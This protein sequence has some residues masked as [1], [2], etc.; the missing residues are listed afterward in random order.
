MACVR[1]PNVTY[2][3]TQKQLDD[4]IRGYTLKPAYEV[5]MT[6]F[7]EKSGD[8]WAHWRT[9]RGVH[10]AILAKIDARTAAEE[11]RVGTSVMD[12][13]MGAGVDVIPLHI[14]REKRL[15][16]F[17]G[18]DRIFC[19]E[20]D[21]RAVEQAKNLAKEYGV[22]LD[23]ITRL[24][25]QDMF[26]PGSPFQRDKPEIDYAMSSGHSLP[27]L[28]NYDLELKTALN[29]VRQLLRP[30][31]Y[32][33]CDFRNGDDFWRN[34]EYYIADPLN[35]YRYEGKSTYLNAETI[36]VFPVQIGPRL[37]TLGYRNEE[38]KNYT[39]V[40]MRTCRL[41][42]VL[43]W[44][45]DKSAFGPEVPIEILYD[46]QKSPP[47]EGHCEFYQAIVGPV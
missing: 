29:N 24:Y 44:I 47:T 12:L 25:W 5:P 43:S 33:F 30:G 14:L 15:V 10:E 36:T 41:R 37:M 35:N 8:L 9:N 27:G 7:W 3:I 40:R 6:R 20:V 2:S 46:Y 42:K 1:A 16:R 21:F 18:R 19:N 4:I 17:G 31:G 26:A 23:T 32:F 34:A 38:T 45:Q 28:A 11:P 13:A 22:K 39:L